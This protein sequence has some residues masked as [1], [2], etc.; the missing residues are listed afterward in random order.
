MQLRKVNIFYVQFFKCRENTWCNCLLWCLHICSG[1]RSLDKAMKQLGIFE[2]A[3]A[4]V[5]QLRHRF[6]D[7]DQEILSTCAVLFPFRSEGKNGEHITFQVLFDVVPGK[8]P[9]LV[10]CPSLCAMKTNI[11]CEYLNIGTKFDGKY[12]RIPL[13]SCDYHASLPFRPENRSQIH[14]KRVYYTYFQLR[15]VYLSRDAASKTTSTAK[16]YS[17]ANSKKENHYLVTST[18]EN[19]ISKTSD[20]TKLKKLHLALGHGTATGME[21]W[22]KTAGLW[23]PDLKKSISELLLECPCK[24][25][26]EPTPHPVVSRN[27]RET[28]KQSAGSVDIVF[29]EG[30]PVKHAVDKCIGWSET[31]VLRNW[32]HDEQ[33][34]TFAKIWFINMVYQKRYMLTE[35][36]PAA[37][38]LHSTK[39][40]E[41]S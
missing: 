24:V 28:N 18:V 41:L 25:A 19:E 8:L 39:I 27:I 11:N 23:Y 14:K 15:V 7:T 9:F 4:Q 21:D 33:V 34:S 26:I 40:T 10:G 2:L 32:N 38:L 17:L 1:A 3:D 20:T 12:T 36:T 13:K 29:L 31:S 5:K 37:L 22:L 6:G 16:T 30:V 35:N